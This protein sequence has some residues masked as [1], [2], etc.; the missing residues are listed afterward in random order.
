MTRVTRPLHLT[1]TYLHAD[2]F[3]EG[4]LIVMKGG[5]GESFSYRM[6][7]FLP[8]VVCHAYIRSMWTGKLSV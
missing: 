2:L 4:D 7:V 6:R 3:K 8:A 5:K 1:A